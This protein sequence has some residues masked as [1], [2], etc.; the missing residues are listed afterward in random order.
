MFNNP[1]F[2]SGAYFISLI[3]GAVLVFYIYRSHMAH[4]ADIQQQLDKLI[5]CIQEQLQ[6]IAACNPERIK[7]ITLPATRKLLSVAISISR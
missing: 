1:T 2:Q 7:L 4:R 5:E 6:S 3:A